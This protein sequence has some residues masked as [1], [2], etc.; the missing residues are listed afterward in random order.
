MRH[1][2]SKTRSH[3]LSETRCTAYR[4]PVCLAS[5][6]IITRKQAS[7]NGANKESFGFL[8]TCGALRDEGSSHEHS[9][10]GASGL[11]RAA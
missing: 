8:L 3:G 6:C 4:K 11:G 9:R 5:R 10:S 2:L 1:G 7:S